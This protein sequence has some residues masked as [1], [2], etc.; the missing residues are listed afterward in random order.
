MKRR[1]HSEAHNE[2]AAGD[3]PRSGRPESTILLGR[4]ALFFGI[5]AVGCSIDLWTK[6]W[7]FDRLGNQLV[8]GGPVR[9][10]WVLIDGIL[11]LETH[12]NEGAL[13]GIG[14]GQITLFVVLSLFAALGILAWVLVGGAIRDR[15]LVVSLGMILGGILGNLYDRLGLA[16]TEWGHGLAHHQAGEPVYAVRDW[17]HFQIRSI[18]FDWAIFNIA[19]SLLVVG[20]AL[21]MCHALRQPQQAAEPAPDVASAQ[22]ASSPVE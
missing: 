9:E 15:M 6:S 10:P 18:G 16:A 3:S 4:L 13:F 14:Q 11:S 2:I 5:A 1:R 17:I 20:A 21:L 22:P 8:S 7:I 12:L 19:D